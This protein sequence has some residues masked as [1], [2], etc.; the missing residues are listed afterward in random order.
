MRG[1]PRP[2]RDPRIA[3]VPCGHQRFCEPCANEVERHGRGCPI[4]RTDIQ[5]IL[6]FFDFLRY[7]VYTVISDFLHR[8]TWSF[9]YML[10]RTCYY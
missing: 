3:L 1:L 2:H 10:C 4:C 6:C 5:M 8:T 9:S 7:A